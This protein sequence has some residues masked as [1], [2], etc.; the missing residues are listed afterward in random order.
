MKQQNQRRGCV[1]CLVIVLVIAIVA[2]IIG[3]GSSTPNAQ[4][5]AADA[6]QVDSTVATDS[7]TH[8]DS[9][10][11]TATTFPTQTAADAATTNAFDAS[12]SPFAH[13][14]K[15]TKILDGDAV[16]SHVAGTILLSTGDLPTPFQP[17]S[18]SPQVH[19]YSPSSVWDAFE[20]LSAQPDVTRGLSSISVD[21][22]HET[23][24]VKARNLLPLA[25]KEATEGDADGPHRPF[26]SEDKLNGVQYLRTIQN[27]GGYWYAVYDAVF[28]V[29]RYANKVNVLVNTTG[30]HDTVFDVTGL[31]QYLNLLIS[32][33]QDSP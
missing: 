13:R 6:T 1:G 5:P 3:S 24:S 25:I 18:G 10:S 4:Q 7:A 30:P 32:R 29:G 15:P 2:G 16:S 26:R 17:M 28:A 20:W 12:L 11:A 31:N 8:N 19:V 22:R 23:T 9:A 21:I 14:D 27:Q 33:E